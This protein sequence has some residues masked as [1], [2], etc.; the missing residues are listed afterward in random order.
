MTPQMAAM[1]QQYQQ[2]VGAQPSQAA[3]MQAQQLQ[4]QQIQ[5]Q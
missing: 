1:M 5:A 3:Q 2:Q 4:A